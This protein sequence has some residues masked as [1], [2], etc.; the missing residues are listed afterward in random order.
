MKCENCDKEHDGKYSSGRFCGNKCARG[1]STKAKR[2]EISERVRNTL[3]SWDNSDRL[4]E[5]C[6]EFFRPKRKTARFCSNSCSGK[7]RGK[8]PEII[9]KIKL[10]I[11]AKV[12]AGEW[13]GWKSRKKLE[14]SYPE[15]Y[16]M[17]V[18]D[19]ANIKYEYEKKA[20]K[21]FIDFA[22]EDCNRKIALEIDGKQHYT[23]E[24]RIISDIKKDNFLSI[25]GWIVYR[26]RWF[27]PT[28]KKNKKLLYEQIEEFKNFYK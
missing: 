5:E 17:E 10:S 24:K 18:L 2:K 26:I 27:N 9:K 22:I 23:D 7:N 19:N 4:C 25:E 13:E 8:N 3:I 6:E 12:K 28:I 15:K 21:Y 1:F 20:G 16:F 11:N 14:P